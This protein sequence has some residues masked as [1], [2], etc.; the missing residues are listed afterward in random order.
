[1]ERDAERISL[2]E[3][4]ACARAIRSAPIH[5]GQQA[6]GSNRGKGGA[7]TPALAAIE[8]VLQSAEIYTRAS[9]G[10]AFSTGISVRTHA[11]HRSGDTRQSACTSKGIARRIL[12][13]CFPAR[14]IHSIEAQSL[15][16]VRAGVNGMQ[17]RDL[18]GGILG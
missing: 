18:H 15:F 7:A 2:A 17:V 14:L 13:V 10:T 5:L 9:S 16:Q 6:D 8:I 12:Q 11:A 4:A 3:G 1:M